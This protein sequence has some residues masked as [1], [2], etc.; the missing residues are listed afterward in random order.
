[1][2]IDTHTHIYLKEFDADCDSVI[3][4]AIQ[5]G[6]QK[7]MLPNIDAS[8][9]QG[10]LALSSKYPGTIYPMAGLHP[11]S[12][13]SNFRLELDDVAIHVSDKRIIAIGETGIDLYWDRS[14][15]REQQIAFAEQIDL[16]LQFDLP[17]VIHMRNSFAEI[18]DVLNAYHSKAPRLL[19]HCFSGSPAEA[20]L[21]INKGYLL[22]IGGVLTFKNAGLREVV[23][24][25]PLDFLMLET[26]APYLAPVPYRGKRNEPAYITIIA[27]EMASLKEMNYAEVCERTTRNALEFF[28]I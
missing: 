26:D 12:V 13:K 2:L 28:R 21:I 22:G 19:F 20:E 7:M 8:T 6:I 5:S 11:T 17:L 24:R 4:A 10:I 14:Y 1:M 3:T 25:T 15:E 16:A 23:K 9:Q 18:W 27:S